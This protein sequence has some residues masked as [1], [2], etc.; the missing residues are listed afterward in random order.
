MLLKQIE[1]QQTNNPIL[2]LNLSLKKEIILWISL[3]TT[4]VLKTFTQR[5]FSNSLWKS[6]IAE[7]RVTQKH[8]TT[9]TCV[10]T[11]IHTTVTVAHLR[12]SYKILELIHTLR[13]ELTIDYLAHICW[14]IGLWRTLLD[15]EGNKLLRIP[16][17]FRCLVH[18]GL[19]GQEC[20]GI[21]G[22][23][24][25]YLIS[26]HFSALLSAHL[27]AITYLSEGK[28]QILAIQTN[29][30]SYSLCQRLLD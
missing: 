5:M 13:I 14:W 20:L 15:H 10:P 1:T 17:E 6:A 9:H 8:I 21:E 11:W 16:I 4:R 23:H 28:I 18:G 7:V 25:P 3:E 27:A 29:P 2:I 26:Y 24:L 30:I 22:I 12:R 19:G